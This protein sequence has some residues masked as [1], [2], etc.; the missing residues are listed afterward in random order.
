MFPFG[1]VSPASDNDAVQPAVNSLSVEPV[2]LVWATVS[3]VALNAKVSTC[4]VQLKL[5]KVRPFKSVGAKTWVKF[6]EMKSLWPFAATPLAS[7][8]PATACFPAAQ[9]ETTLPR[10]FTWPPLALKVA[11]PPSA[12]VRVNAGLVNVI[13]LVV[14][15]PVIAT[16]WVLDA[17]VSA[18]AK[19]GNIPA[20]AA[21]AGVLAVGVGVAKVDGVG[22]VAAAAGA[23]S[24]PP[25]PHPVVSAATK[26][27]LSQVESV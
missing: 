16:F 8:V 2:G 6:A 23:A 27:R 24:L 17:P 1:R 7:D 3:P 18:I 13:T 5:E 20:M 4:P 26:A 12:P 21:V 9:Y 25:P 15:E 11:D 10:A 14:P 22:D 19:N